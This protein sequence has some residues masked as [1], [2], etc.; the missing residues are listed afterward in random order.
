MPFLAVLNW[1]GGLLRYLRVVTPETAQILYGDTLDLAILDVSKHPLN[2]RTVAVPPGITVVLIIIVLLQGHKMIPGCNR[3]FL[4]SL[5]TPLQNRR[6]N[7]P[8]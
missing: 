3:F 2:A 8:Y 4:H 6:Q 7:S 1:N 5:H